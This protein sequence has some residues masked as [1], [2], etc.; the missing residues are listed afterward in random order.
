MLRA[1]TSGGSFC[2]KVH[3]VIHSCSTATAV[4][5]G[6]G[7]DTGT[8]GK[9]SLGPGQPGQRPALMQ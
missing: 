4:T 1:H 9:V 3:R 7:E 6:G 5:P 2:T 8:V